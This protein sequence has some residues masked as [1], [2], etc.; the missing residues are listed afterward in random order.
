MPDAVL[1][2]TER[3][4]RAYGSLLAVSDVDV[5]VRR[6]ELRSIIGPNGAGKTTF[7]RLISGETV[8]TSGRIWFDGTDITGMPQHAT[9]RLGIAKSYQITNIFPHLSVLENVRVAVQGYARSFN[10]W[11]RADRLTEVRERAEAILK[12]VGLGAKNDLLAAHL[13]HGEKRHLELGIALASS[14]T[15]LLLDEPTAG[16]TPGETKEATTL[17]RRIAAARGLT[18]LLIEHDMSV[19]MGISDRI[20]VLHFGEKIAEGAPEQ[21]RNDPQ[22]IEAYL[23]PPDD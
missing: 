4:T 21:I 7:F 17:V 12:S 19:V 5:S 9:T 8:P 18:V 15:L 23:G 16:M 14:P 2:R 1:L 10:F 22:V 20:A 13:S 3:L 6:G 11:S